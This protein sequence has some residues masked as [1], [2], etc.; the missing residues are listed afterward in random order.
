MGNINPN[1]N[2]PCKRCELY[3]NQPP[4]LSKRAKSDVMWVGISAQKNKNDLEFEPLD[5]RT[6]SGKFIKSIEDQ[7]PNVSFYKTNLVKCLPLND[8]NKIRY[9]SNDEYLKCFDNLLDE[10][11]TVNPKIVFF[12][13]GLVSEFVYG[14]FGIERERYIL[15][16]Y[17]KTSIVSI[18]HPS[19]LMIYKRKKLDEYC[20]KIIGL[21]NSNT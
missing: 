2:S 11:R 5:V 14:Q 19:Y 7:L 8:Q 18:D 1:N 6:N 16:Q 15:Q 9:P 20:D 12:L 4:I 3:K 13:G 10:I 17:K 21:I